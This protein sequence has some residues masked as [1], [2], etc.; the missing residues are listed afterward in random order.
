MNQDIAFPI[1]GGSNFQRSRAWDSSYSQN[2]Y[3]FYDQVKDE[4]I[5]AF[6]A[7]TKLVSEPILDLGSYKGRS[8]GAIALQ[9]TAYVVIGNTVY[10]VVSDL[11]ATEIGTIGTSEGAV[12][13]CA[14][15]HYI[16]IVDG[17][18]GWVY[19]VTG[20]SFTQITDSVFP[21]SPTTCEQQQGYFL[22]NN[23]GT[24]TMYQSMIDNPMVW[25]A[26]TTIQV[27]FNSSFL[28]APLIGIH[29]VNARLFAMT[30]TFIQVYEV[31]PVVGIAFRP[32]KNLIFGYGI[33]T[34]AGVAKGAAGT[35]NQQVPE[36]LIFLC[37]TNDGTKKV[38]LTSGNPPEVVS[39]PSIEYRIN[40]LTNPLDV[41]SFIWT[42]NG[43]TFAH[44]NFTTDNITIVYNV[45][46]KTWFD[47]RTGLNRYF[48]EDFFFF[49][50]YKLGLSYLDGKIYQLSE[51]FTTDSDVPITRARISDNFRIEGYKNFTVAY[52]ELYFQQGVGLVGRLEPDALFYKPGSDP[53][54]FLYL[55]DDGGQT[56]SQPMKQPLGIAA[57]TL[58]TTRFTGLGTHKDLTFKIVIQEPVQVFLIGAIMS[59]RVA[60][61]SG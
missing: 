19:D 44:F 52:L 24:Q 38:M 31:E 13:M 18:G 15:S 43:Q 2:W 30:A 6:F 42:E 37:R 21:E 10:E 25:S 53:Q 57:Q 41:T 58:V 23:T 28:A 33:L 55:S 20:A 22:V 50:S 47:A 7:G 49:N 51:N 39:T 9:T 46:N 34:D 40:Q 29:S 56:F 60:E 17:T 12:S 59:F 3:P 14:G 48:I 11:N 54:V 27:N 45:T 16:M 26:F 36:I 61:G 32:D 1:V 4:W 35:L 8:G 5:Q